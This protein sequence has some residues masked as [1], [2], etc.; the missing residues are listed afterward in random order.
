M[1]T[2]RTLT[3]ACCLLTAV[4]YAWGAEVTFRE[5]RG[6]GYVGPKWD[7]VSIITTTDYAYPPANDS[8]WTS[9]AIFVS[10]DPCPPT[11]G[12][13]EYYVLL[14]IKDLLTALPL[15]SEDITSATLTLVGCCGDGDTVVAYRV[16]TDW[17]TKEAGTNECNTAGW[18]YNGS[19]YSPWGPQGSI[20]PFSE[21]NYY[22]QAP[23]CATWAGSSYQQPLELDVTDQLKAMYDA[24]EHCGWAVTNLDASD[25][26]IT[27]YNPGAC[28][29]EFEPTL[30]IV[31]E[32]AGT[33]GLSVNRGSG[34]GQYAAGTEVAVT[35]NDIPP[36]AVFGGW[37]GD[38]IWLYDD[39]SPETTLLMPPC[40]VSITAIIEAPVEVYVE[41]GTGS[42]DLGFGVCLGS[43]GNVY[44]GGQTQGSLGAPNEGGWDIFVGKYTSDLATEMWMEQIGGWA[45]DSGCCVS[46]DGAGNLYFSGYTQWEIGGQTNIGDVDAF[47]GKYYDEV[48][49]GSLCWI[50]QFGTIYKDDAGGICTDGLGNI[51]IAGTNFGLGCAYQDAYLA[52]YYDDGESGSQVWTTQFATGEIDLGWDVSIDGE[53]NA[54]VCGSTRGEFEPSGPHVYDTF[55]AACYDDGESCSQC[56]IHQFGPEGISPVA[57]GCGTTTDAEGNVFVAGFTDG[58]IHG[59]EY[60]GG[61]DAFV[62]K[63]DADGEFLWVRLLGTAEDDMCGYQAPGGVATDTWGNVYIAGYTYG[64]LGRP[65]AGLSD[66]F[67]AKYDPDG[68]L[69]WV[70]QFGT[71]EEDRAGPIAV[72]AYGSAYIAGLTGGEEGEWDWIGDCDAFLAKLAGFPVYTLT[73]NSGSGSG[74]YVGGTIVDIEAGSPPEGMKFRHWVGD[75]DGV[76]DVYDGS[77]TFTMPAR[78]AELTANYTPRGDLNLDGFVGQGDLDIVLDN[79]GDTVPPADPRAD[80]SGD[81]FVGQ[82]DL[83]VVLDDW[84]QG[85]PPGGEG[86]GGR[87]GG[88]D[89]LAAA[90]ESGGERDSGG[91]SVDIV[92]FDTPETTDLVPPE[93]GGMTIPADTYV[94]NDVVVTTETDWLGAQLILET[95]TDGDI[96][97][98]PLGG[99][100]SPSPGW[101]GPYP[102]LQYDTYV[103]NGV[104]GSGV[105]TL[106][107]VNLYGGPCTVVFDDQLLQIGWNTTQTE[108]GELPLARVTIANDAT[109]EW[110]FMV[111]ASPAEGPKVLTAGTIVAGEMVTDE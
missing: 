80:P 106:G 70:T 76:A 43:G 12:A 34:G 101:F 19:K 22:E 60:A 25:A 14:G 57:H 52:K 35:A 102:T 13:D 62:A 71:D 81:S 36:G 67:V 75:T 66:A 84:G 93:Y 72:D 29:V 26:G 10:D 91:L 94:T 47:V 58:S 41:I 45:D 40:D 107:P 92:S 28:D 82:A 59:Q 32:S 108:I 98:H 27:I 100:I 18:F 89:M 51:C 11:Q 63:Y 53:G 88:L 61:Y 9:E 6:Q 46:T 95:D 86:E 50:E 110:A 68:N 20:V 5:A 56:W 8:D 38:T 31:Y 24:G 99:T 1:T 33:Y 103:S 85:T 96:F 90:P 54:Y 21:N 15:E 2:Q 74:E 111:T 37:Y 30:K 55:L 69:L 104:L 73:V 77:T 109:G 4:T 78:N 16:T 65:H 83:D 105:C 87:G 23:V 49:S 3:A 64:S 17:L 79:W 48:E 97:Q 39:Q 44:I 7:V 42:T